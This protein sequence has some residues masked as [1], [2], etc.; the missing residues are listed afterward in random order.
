[1]A[2]SDLTDASMLKGER[3]SFFHS[4]LVSLGSTDEIWNSVTGVISRSKQHFI[5]KAFH[6]IHT[7]A[8]SPALRKRNKKSMRTRIDL[9][10]PLDGVTGKVVSLALT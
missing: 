7:F 5:I 1:M 10:L 4:T 3:P 8:E 6:P 9:L 2:K